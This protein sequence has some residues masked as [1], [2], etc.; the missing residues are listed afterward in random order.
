MNVEDS[1]EGAVR[2]LARLGHAGMVLAP[3]AQ[4]HVGESDRVRDLEELATLACEDNERLTRELESAR[5]DIVR[6]Q[7]Q[8]LALQ[9]MSMG[10]QAN[11][12]DY[13]P[14]RVRSSAFYFFVIAVLGAGAAGLATFRRGSG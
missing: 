7:Q 2:R 13:A 4:D 1:Y 14:R 10:A 8:V 12:P 5:M 9:T 11:E 3:P 6:L